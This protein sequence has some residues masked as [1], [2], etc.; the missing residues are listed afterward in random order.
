MRARGSLDYRFVFEAERLSGCIVRRS[1][2][3]SGERRVAVIS[4]LR[5]V[6]NPCQSM[7][8]ILTELMLTRGDSSSPSLYSKSVSAKSV[9]LEKRVCTTV[10]SGLKCP[11]VL[12]LTWAGAALRRARRFKACLS[13]VS[14]YYYSGAL[15]W[16]CL[17][18]C[19]VGR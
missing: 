15:S 1:N 14:S 3:W 2:V 9:V 10:Q 17:P 11:A 18:L 7:S 12:V 16:V 13:M 8:S 6:N 4:K 19:G 5:P